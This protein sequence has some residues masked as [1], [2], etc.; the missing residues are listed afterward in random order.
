M[1][2]KR[3]LP[4]CT[5]G[6]HGGPKPC[7]EGCTCKKHTR[8]GGRGRGSRSKGLQLKC[9]FCG[10]AFPSS[11]SD[12]RFCSGICC[13][14]SWR[15]QNPGEAREREAQSRAR[16]RSTIRERQRVWRAGP[17]IVED[18]A[19]MWQA[20]GG[21]CYLCGGK[22]DPKVEAVHLD[23]DHSCC[24]P[25]RSCRICR[26]GLAHQRCNVAIGLAEDSPDR[27]RRMADALE[28]AQVAFR[29][30]KTE[31]GAGEQLALS[32]LDSTAL[33]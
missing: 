28:A 18:Q 22:L 6:R 4:G 26:R 8:S 24:A 32:V 20:Q 17:W 33:F 27:L 25:I 1:S 13:K 21:C 15:K 16:R 9:E 11:R 5:C 19:A 30:R 23:H 7:P 3:C 12:A 14:K 10:K 31:A 2:S 29:Q